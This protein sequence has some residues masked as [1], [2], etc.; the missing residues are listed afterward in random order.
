MRL[1]GLVANENKNTTSDSGQET[2]QSPPK[3]PVAIKKFRRPSYLKS[4]SSVV[5]KVEN[6]TSEEEKTNK[7]VFK[8]KGK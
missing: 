7:S 5:P 8:P 1:L 3:G 2:Q 4:V 6:E